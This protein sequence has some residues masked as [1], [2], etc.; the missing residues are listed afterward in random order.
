MSDIFSGISGIRFP[1]ARINGGGPLPTQL[2]GPEGINGDPDGMI[3]AN[4]DLLSGVVP[5][6]YE[7]GTGRMGS[8]R[9]Y[10]QIPHRRQY[11]IPKLY[12]PSP[13]GTHKIEVSHPVDQGDIAFIIRIRQRSILLYPD[14]PPAG[15]KGHTNQEAF[16]NLATANYLLRGIQNWMHEVAADARN[17][18]PVVMVVGAAPVQSLDISRFFTTSTH[19]QMFQFRK[20]NLWYKLFQEMIEPYA[21]RLFTRTFLQCFIPW[22]I[23][24]G[25]EKQG[26]LHE[27]GLAPV[28]AAC[29]HVTTMTLDGQNRDLVNY[30]QGVDVSAG[31]EL[32]FVLKLKE[33]QHYVL[34]HYYKGVVTQGFTSREHAWQI[35]PKTLS[36]T[37]DLDTTDNVRRIDRVLEFLTCPQ[38][39][40]YWRVAQTFTAK[41]KYSTEDQFTDDSAFLKGQLL[42]VTFAPVWKHGSN[43]RHRTR[44]RAYFPEMY[45][46]N[47][48]YIAWHSAF[49]DDETDAGNGGGGGGGS[50]AGSGGG[51]GSGG[52]SVLGSGGDVGTDVIFGAEAACD[53]VQAASAMDATDTTA[54]EGGRGRKR[55]DAPPAASVPALP[56]EETV[57]RR[58]GVPKKKRVDPIAQPFSTQPPIAQPPNP[59]TQPQIAPNH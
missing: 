56:E 46:N 27:T 24:A 22:G 25:S 38:S 13:D 35:V 43:L 42:Q 4:S 57:R 28:Q 15:S 26:G 55:V 3:N 6:Q 7:P 18:A 23:C 29:S 34:N 47:G 50:V 17:Q 44:V 12:L 41:R 53:R 11:F 14:D 59:I 10:Q 36:Y 9:N 40:G 58:E 52:V 54:E 20:N 21:D 37:A 30:W 39:L 1:D 2:S 31:D 49:G 33:T 45:N 32:V 16:C 5:Y 19:G 48:R 8:D 51:G